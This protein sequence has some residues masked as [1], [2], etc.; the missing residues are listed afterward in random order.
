MLV[1][2]LRRG[3]LFAAV[4]EGAGFFAEG[5]EAGMVGLC[6][7]R[8]EGRQEVAGIAGEVGGGLDHHADV[9]VAGGAT[10]RVGH[11]QA[12]DGSFRFR[13]NRTEV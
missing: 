10:A 6:Q 9:V 7:G 4:V 13:V 11:A 8:A 5:G 2:F 3:H 12:P 1:L